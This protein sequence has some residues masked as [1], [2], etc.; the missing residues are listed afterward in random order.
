MF[1]SSTNPLFFTNYFMQGTDRFINIF[2]LNISII[3]IS[4]VDRC[5]A[6]GMAD[7]VVKHARIVIAVWI[8]G[9]VLLTPLAIQLNNVLSY[10]ETTF[11]PENTESSIAD[12][13]ISEEFNSSAASMTNTS[14][15][16]LVIT[17]IDADSDKGRR[18]YDEFKE[19]INGVY[20]E[21]IVSY[22][23]V[24]G[25]IL[26][27]SDNISRQLV[28]MIINTT[29]YLEN[30]TYMLAS[31]YNNTINETTMMKEMIDYAREMI[32][33]TSTAYW[34]IRNNISMLHDLIGEIRDTL[35]TMDRE[36]MYTRGNITLMYNSLRGLNYTITE[37]NNASY[38][39]IFTYN[40]FYY[41]I[42]RTYYYLSKATDAYQTG[43]LDENDTS[44]VIYYTN[45]SSLG[46]VDPQLIY[47][48]FNTTYSVFGN[49]TD[50]VNDLVLAN[51]TKD[52][53]YQF[54]TLYYGDNKQLVELFTALLAA[55]N[56][57]FIETLS[58]NESV[59]NK[60]LLNTYTT[61]TSLAGIAQ[62]SV[63]YIVN[64]VGLKA[65]YYLEPALSDILS[66]MM[67]RYGFS[68]SENITLQIAS[69]I[70][71]LGPHPSASD[72]MDGVINSTMLLVED[73]MGYTI[74]GIRHIL[75]K[76]YVEGPSINLV[77]EVFI[78]STLSMLKGLPENATWLI[79]QTM[80]IVIYVDNDASGKLLS[81]EELLENTT[82]NIVKSMMESYMGN[83]PIEFPEDLL[84]RLYSIELNDTLLDE[85]TR[86]ILLDMMKQYPENLNIPLEIPGFQ[87]N[88]SILNKTIPVI[89]DIASH[90]DP[91][92]DTMIYNATLTL[93]KNLLGGNNSY[94][95][96]IEEVYD[97]LY[98]LEN[99]SVYS[100]KMVVDPLFREYVEQYISQYMGLNNSNNELMGMINDTIEW[101]INNYPVTN[102]SIRQFVIGKVYGLIN[103]YIGEDPAFKEMLKNIDL[104]GLVNR[105]YGLSLNDEDKIDEIVSDVK[106]HIVRYFLEN[107]G[108]YLETL[109]SSDNTTITVS[110]TPLGESDDERYENAL[111]VRDKALEVFGKYFSNVK[112]YVTGGV[113]SRKEMESVGKGD[114]D[115][116]QRFSFLL[117][118]II[119]F[120]V[121]ES[122]FAVLIPF[123]SIG[124]A[125]MLASGIVYLIASNVMSISNW[126]TVLMTTTSLGLGIDYTTY[127][128][129][130]LREI[131]GSNKDISFEEAVAEAVR[132]A[133]DGILAS[134][135][136]DIIGFAVLMIA[137]D[138]PF[139]RVMG[140]VVPIAIFSVF[141]ASL[142]LIPAITALIGRSKWFWWPRD[143]WKRKPS[144]H[145]SRLVDGIMRY[146]SIV[147][148][149]F[150]VLSIPA[151]ITYLNFQGSHD[152]QL[153]LPE[154]TQ[155]AE[156]YKLLEEKIGA[157]LTSPTY[158]VIRLD[159]P[160]DND[161]LYLIEDLSSRISGLEH[162]KIVYGPTRPYGK[163][164]ENLTM[165]YVE[166]FNGTSYI[167][168]DNRTIMLNIVLDVP[169]E[170]DEARN[171]VR[172]LRSML[173][174]Y[175]SSHKVF[176]EAYVGGIAAAMVDLDDLLN[177]NFWHRIIPVSIILMF[178]ALT[179]SLRGVLAS[180]I[181]LTVIY[182]GTTWSIWLSSILF[183]NIF[184]K[185][186]LWFLPLVLLVVLLGVG[187]DYNSFYLV[188]VRDLMETLDPRRALSRSARE[189]GKMIIGLALILTSA[190][191]SLMFTSMW[192]M[193]EMGFVLTLGVLIV[194]I[195]AVYILSPA[196]IAYLG[197]KAW[198]PFKKYMERRRGEEE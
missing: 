109:K 104:K 159:R 44:T 107:M 29:G 30:T 152:I 56:Y 188:K 46:P 196:I 75:S 168:W 134:A 156:A 162:V 174:E 61:N 60:L 35:K 170:S 183:K 48:V 28:L 133:R 154:G 81:D 181:T 94:T 41:D 79:N 150:I 124:S 3:D 37:L 140:I 175:I 148:L 119:L 22:Y 121:V 197:Y 177:I 78:N 179:F 158:V 135:S 85:M 84:Y 55:Y 160:V 87:F 13:I 18:A 195:S 21:N 42:S 131:I 77:R 14:S 10:E 1:L 157:S 52:I 92:N 51:I 47:I 112:A 192:A 114:V 163:P 43:V 151:T 137:W 73:S 117:T 20:A 9:I 185:P 93:I 38:T 23:D 70:I 115:R 180:L 130:R 31:K 126:A 147:V 139:L 194:A 138:F 24:Y 120:L 118:F 58:M 105:S 98:S 12:K 161:T 176:R 16:V 76:L 83:M 54:I 68:V 113:V 190:Y 96:M 71:N 166:L 128:L 25:D 101:I 145:R 106:T 122:V 80:N 7:L 184:G 89:I 64:N 172:D 45:M 2:S 82:I 141:L 167:S 116:V 33:N 187:V 88:E 165:R 26:N 8:L 17:G 153:Y 189:S 57:G 129:H 164:L 69:I 5:C 102:N 193:R 49:N 155:T 40:R 32:I 86:E 123:I 100:I 53:L 36:Y 169:A 4:R 143:P 74:P 19:G 127:F 11:L 171:F 27:E 182:V 97:E 62:D 99:T 173:R 103:D 108:V 65:R 132:R 125:I 191:I 39:L 198:W 111:K 66:S 142:T 67:K 149:L 63:Y 50:L 15:I 110:F 91:R 136:T 59:D 186:L 6:M 95:E 178:I 90:I 72:L 144:D 34:M 146:R